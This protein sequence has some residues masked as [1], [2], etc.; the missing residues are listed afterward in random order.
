MTL[1]FPGS[2]LESVKKGDRVSVELALKPAGSAA[3]GPTPPAASPKMEKDKDKG[4]GGSTGEKK[5]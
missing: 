5:Y 1:H 4:A 3:S 2:A